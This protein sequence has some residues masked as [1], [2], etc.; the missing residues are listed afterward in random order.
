MSYQEQILAKLN[1]NNNNVKNT[2]NVDFLINKC[3]NEIDNENINSSKKEKIN[4]ICAKISSYN[5]IDFNNINIYE[6]VSEYFKNENKNEFYNQIYKTNNNIM[7]NEKKKEILLK[8]KNDNDT[9]QIFIQ[10]HAHDF[11]SNDID[12]WKKRLSIN[13]VGTDNQNYST[14]ISWVAN[15]DDLNENILSIFM[16][17]IPVSRSTTCWK[18]FPVDAFKKFKEKT[19]K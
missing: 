13:F 4:I 11:S 3:I 5:N 7:K 14:N 8:G 16:F 2:N 19:T 12:I 18:Y 9:I 17:N 15:L 10:I 1:N 6:K